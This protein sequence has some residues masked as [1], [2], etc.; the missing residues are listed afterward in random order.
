MKIILCVTNDIV[1][2]QRINRIAA[3]LASL[4]S[5]IVIAGIR[6]P[7]SL[8]VS[9]NIYKARRFNLIFKKGPLFYMEFNTRLFFYLLFTNAAAIVSNDLDTLPAAFIASKLKREVLIYDSHELFT[10]LPELVGRNITRKIWER[11]ERLFLPRVKYSYT[12]SPSIALHYSTKY[13]INMEVIRNMPY[14][15]NDNA[16]ASPGRVFQKQIIYQGAL[17]MGRGIELLI[18]AMQWINDTG[19]IIAG[20]GYAENELHSLAA[21]LHLE[22]K[23]KFTGRIKPEDLLVYTRASD[24]GVSLE[25]NL[26]L[27]YYYAL[28]N[29]L[30]D[31][32]QSGIP[33]LVSDLPEMA[34]VIKTYGAGQVTSTRD[35]HELAG[36]IS[37]MLNDDQARITWKENLKQ[38]AQDLCWENE[39]P[40]LIQIYRKALF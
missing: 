26:G 30:F 28:P 31:Y 19:V 33:V 18:R 38:A 35:P 22:E 6:R 24:L 15:L 8:P 4:P 12:V 3:T 25:E 1:T 14:R 23:V 5:E 21:S 13:G 39:A 36:I 9:G 17:N 37:R 20:S 16:P 7:G 11:L 34:A 32:I 40:K 2:D 29:K 27:N 10:E